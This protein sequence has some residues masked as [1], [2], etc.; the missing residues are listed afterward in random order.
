MTQET[1]GEKLIERSIYIFGIA[2]ALHLAGLFQHVPLSSLAGMA[3]PAW[4]TLLVFFAGKDMLDKKK[5]KKQGAETETGGLAGFRKF[6]YRTLLFYLIV[7]L[8]A[9]W[10]LMLQTPE[11]SGDITGE[12]VQTFL[13]E[14]A[15]YT[16]NPMTGS[17]FTEGM[18][19]RFQV[20]GLPTFYALLCRLTGCPAVYMVY[21]ILPVV[22]LIL[23]YVVYGLWARFLF[24]KDDKKQMTFL[25]VVAFLFQFGCYGTVT[26]GARLLTAGWQGET[27]RALVLLPYALLCL[28]KKRWRGVILCILAEACMVWTFYGAGFVLLMTILV[29][30]IRLAG[31]RRHRLLRQ[32]FKKEGKG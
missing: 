24:P 26:D 14:D 5:K 19:A 4:L 10:F 29:G 20:L 21:R 28:R 23:T 27:I 16:V 8:Q 3:L 30:A 2:E 25:L 22:T 31:H 9:V 32:N 1:A 6:P 11:I 12:T 15:I 7:L 17:A 13:T 18:P